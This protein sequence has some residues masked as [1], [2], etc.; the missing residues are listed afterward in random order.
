MITSVTRILAPATLLPASKPATESARR[1]HKFSNQHHT[2]V[3]RYPRRSFNVL[4]RV[5]KA[6]LCVLSRQAF[7]AV[8]H[9]APANTAEADQFRHEQVTRAVGA[10]GLR[11][12]RQDDYKALEAFFLDLA[13]ESG[14]AL[15]AHMEHATEPARVALETLR[16]ECE[17]RGI[18]L[19]YAEAICRK[20]YKC[21]LADADANQLWRLT[22]TVK[23]RRRNRARLHKIEEPF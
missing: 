4:T 17:E 23:N 1:E 7:E 16:A 11:L 2:G 22:F 10:D 18:S 21:E 5:Q 14:Q 15:T 12:C 19:N 13:G 20:Q 8:N 9:R 6:R 3:N